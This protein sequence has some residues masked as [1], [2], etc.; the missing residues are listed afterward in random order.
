MFILVEDTV[1][2]A[3]MDAHLSETTSAL[4]FKSIQKSF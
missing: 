1:Y 3:N 2:V 4:L